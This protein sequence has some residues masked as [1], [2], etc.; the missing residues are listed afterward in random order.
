MQFSKTK[1]TDKLSVNIDRV[2]YI[3]IQAIHFFTR[4]QA[5]SNAIRICKEQAL[6]DQVQLSIYL[7][8]R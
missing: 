7:V 2:Y 6:D 5:Y 4:A 1:S 3:I 8:A